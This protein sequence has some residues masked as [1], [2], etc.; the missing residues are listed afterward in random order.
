MTDRSETVRKIGMFSGARQY[1]NFANFK[2]LLP[3]SEMQQSARPQ[4]FPDAAHIKLPDTFS[5]RDG[6][7]SSKAFLERTD[8]GGLLVLQ[9]GNI[10]Y[11][12]YWL[13]GGKDV[14]WISWSVAKSF[15]SALVGIAIEEGH[16]GSID[17]SISRYI[18]VEPGTAYD[19][20]SIKHV[21]QMSSGAR[22]N[23]DY[24][25]PKSDINRFAAALSGR[26]TFAA[27]IAS[28]PR[29][30]DP[31]VLCRYN[32]ADTQALGSLLVN[33][34]GR[35]I[36]S[37][38][39]EKLCEPLGFE[40]PG[41]WLLDPGDM[42]MA[43]GGLNLVARDYAKLGELYRCAGQWNGQQVVP[44]S[45]VQSSLRNDEPHLQAGAVEVAD[46]KFGIGYGYQWWI[47]QGDRGEFTGIGV[48]NQFVFVDPSRDVTIVKLTANPVYG[49]PDDDHMS[50]LETIAF[51]RAIAAACDN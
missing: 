5:Y 21:L 13:S 11:E 22:W 45:W 29:E 8:T 50:E 17:E 49:S 9:E 33:A 41:Y 47:P 7:I 35:S 40:S 6:E 3:V 48:Y 12:N 15:V 27:F 19:G 31:G 18:D 34:T 46:M 38:M 1:E 51:L 16:I 4:P 24:G 42:E 44:A 43:F 10:R 2:N 26:G 25:D 20:T 39:Q 30:N 37:Y 32:S 36:T 14:Q 23:E 28:L